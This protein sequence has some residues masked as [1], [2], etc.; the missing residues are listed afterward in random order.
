MHPLTRLFPLSIVVLIGAGPLQGREPTMQTSAHSPANAADVEA[1]TRLNQD[2]IDAVRGADVAR[3]EDLLAT[4]FLCTMADGSLLDRTQFIDGVAKAAKLPS[5][6]AH[7]VNI[8]LIGDVAIIHA[9]TTFSLGDGQAKTGRY[10]D[11]WAKRDGRWQAV[12]AHVTRR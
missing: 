9:S 5:L 7:D 10:T 6:E 1:L 12:A 8:R 2:Y 11:I 3:F 4:D